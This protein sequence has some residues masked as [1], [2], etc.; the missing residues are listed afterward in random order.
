M[1][2]GC[3]TAGE[4]F[5]E[6]QLL[7][8]EAVTH[9]PGSQNTAVHALQALRAPTPME[10]KVQADPVGISNSQLDKG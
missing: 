5:R 10:F 7:I 4:Q 2:A 3:L 9:I 8:T 6:A 1:K